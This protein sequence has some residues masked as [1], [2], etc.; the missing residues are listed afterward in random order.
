MVAPKYVE[1]DEPIAAEDLDRILTD[2][3]VR[4]LGN[5]WDKRTGHA[6]DNFNRAGLVFLFG[7][8]VPI[9]LTHDNI[10]ND[11]RLKLFAE[12]RK[13]GHDEYVFVIDKHQWRGREFEKRVP[14]LAKLFN[15]ESPNE[16]RI[17]FIHP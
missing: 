15:A 13:R 8:D 4:G 14:S 6:M 1:Y 11:W 2:Q 17:Y 5:T 10:Q 3:I 16:S 12:I 9:D 7:K